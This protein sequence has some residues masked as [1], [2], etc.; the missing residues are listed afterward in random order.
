MILQSQVLIYQANGDLIDSFQTTQSFSLAF[1]EQG[2][3]LTASR[4]FVV[5]YEVN[6]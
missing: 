2:E 1:N 5:K 4:P 3:L 6:Q